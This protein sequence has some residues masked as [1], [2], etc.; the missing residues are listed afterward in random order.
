MT[1][2]TP[3]G[4]FDSAADDDLDIASRCSSPIVSGEAAVR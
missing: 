4:D 2:A 3:P 1:C